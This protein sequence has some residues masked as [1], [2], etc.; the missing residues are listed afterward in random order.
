MTETA[1]KPTHFS[2]QQLARVEALRAVN[3][4]VRN[5]SVINGSAADPFD[6]MRLAHFVLHGADL[7]DSQHDE[8]EV[9]R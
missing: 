1:A 8:S 2:E 7:L 5:T 9:A 3:G 6:L 4:Y